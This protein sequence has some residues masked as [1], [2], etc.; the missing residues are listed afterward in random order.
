MNSVQIEMLKGEC[1][2]SDMPFNEYNSHMGLNWQE[3]D[4]SLLAL[5]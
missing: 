5:V 3:W 2:L 1:I 4:Y